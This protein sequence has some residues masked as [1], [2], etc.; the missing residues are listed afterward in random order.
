MAVTPLAVL[1]HLNTIRIILLV[2]LGRIVAPFAVGAGQGDQCTHEFSFLLFHG[3]LSFL[4]MRVS[5]AALRGDL[6]RFVAGRR[7]VSFKPAST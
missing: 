7:T 4:H 1:L 2:F 5:G 3:A 6:A